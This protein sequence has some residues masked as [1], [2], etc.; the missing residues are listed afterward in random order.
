MKTLVKSAFKGLVV[1]TVVALLF[2]GAANVASLFFSEKNELTNK[3]K[4]VVSPIVPIQPIEKLESVLSKVKDVRLLKLN[5][6][7]TIIINEVIS[8][9]SERIAD[10]I[11]EM[12]DSPEPIVLVIDSPGG[13]VFSGEK[14]ISAMESVTSEI[15]TVCDGLCASMAAII[16][17]YGTKRFATD[18]SVLMFHDAAGGLRGRLSE[19]ESMLKMVKRKIEKANHYIANRS[20]VPYEELVRLESSNYWIDSEDALE[21]GFVDSLVRLKNKPKQAAPSLFGE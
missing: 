9:F 1:G 15:Y 11:L 14:I 2:S 4:T 21:R 16:H 13:N 8:I 10:Q 18:R 12:G 19:M 17:Q 3:N 7:R 20:K 6:N 5:P